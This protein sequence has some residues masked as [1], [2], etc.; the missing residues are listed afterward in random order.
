MSKEYKTKKYYTVDFS[1]PWNIS[2]AVRAARLAR[3]PNPIFNCFK[4]AAKLFYTKQNA[5]N[6]E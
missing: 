3:N 6:K 5:K 4:F 2:K 1:Y